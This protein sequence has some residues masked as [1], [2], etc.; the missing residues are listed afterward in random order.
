MLVNNR[1][2]DAQ[3]YAENACVRVEDPTFFNLNLRFNTH[4][5]LANVYWLMGKRELAAE[6]LSFF[7]KVMWKFLRIYPVFHI[8]GLTMG[9]WLPESKSEGP[10]AVYR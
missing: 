4:N 10:S 8:S 2:E 6:K 1:V 9:F 5:F 3:L 7:V